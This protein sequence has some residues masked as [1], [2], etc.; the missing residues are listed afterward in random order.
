M[1][2][3]RRGCQH[4]VKRSSEPGQT[5]QGSEGQEHCCYCLK[6][7]KVH[8]VSADEATGSYI[9]EVHDTHIHKQWHLGR[10]IKHL[11][12]NSLL[13][14][15]F[16][17]W[18]LTLL[19]L[20]KTERNG[21]LYHSFIICIRRYVQHGRETLSSSQQSLEGRWISIVDILWCLQDHRLRLKTEKQSW[22]KSLQDASH[23]RTWSINAVSQDFKSTNITGSVVVSNHWS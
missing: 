15:L 13:K 2:W 8:D 19:V 7:Q 4:P 14:D 9:C 12:W 20:L 23:N 1:Q 16:I 3:C 18:Q 10:N 5:G 21:Q 22:Y 11:N 6:C 17:F